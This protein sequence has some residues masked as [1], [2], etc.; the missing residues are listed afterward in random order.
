MVPDTDVINIIEE[1]S[2]T[3]VHDM[4]SNADD[5]SSLS[6]LKEKILRIAQFLQDLKLLS[7]DF[8]DLEGDEDE[9]QKQKISRRISK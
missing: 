1:M 3:Q 9:K 6:T 8:Q 5:K 4:S 7:Q 2:T